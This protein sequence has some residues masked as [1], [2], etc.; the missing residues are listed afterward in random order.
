M[1]EEFSYLKA[2]VARGELSREDE[3]KLIEYCE[4]LKGWN[5]KLLDIIKRYHAHCGTNQQICGLNFEA[6][7]VMNSE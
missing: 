5:K 7:K 2:K 1:M 3:H 6:E 4:Q